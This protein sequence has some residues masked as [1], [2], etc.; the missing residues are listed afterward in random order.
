MIRSRSSARASRKEPSFAK[1]LAL[2]MT[3]SRRPKR[4]MAAS[5]IACTWP[6]S[7]ISQQAA[8][9]L[10]PAAWISATTASAGA[11]LLP[12]LAAQSTAVVIHHDPRAAAGKEQ[13]MLAANAAT[14]PVMSA[15]W[16]SNLSMVFPRSP[17]GRSVEGNHMASIGCDG[18]A[19]DVTA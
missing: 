14:G 1:V 15:T 13:G 7:P 11:G 19:I 12:I 4:S 17:A 18:L 9:A 8:M 16:S 10:P 5:T 2:W 3:T 6:A